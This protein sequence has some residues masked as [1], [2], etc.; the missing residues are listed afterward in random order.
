V[1]ITAEEEKIRDPEGYAA[2]KAVH[3]LLDDDQSGNDFY[4][5][6]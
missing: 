2:I 1:I 3:L 5:R 4:K 6:K